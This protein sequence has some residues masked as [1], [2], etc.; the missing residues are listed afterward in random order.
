MIVSLVLDE[1]S[2]TGFVN[3][4][5]RMV[6][7]LSRARIACYLIG[8][9]NLFSPDNKDLPEHWQTVL[10]SLS[11]PTYTGG[12]SEPRLL[13]GCLP[14]S[15]SRFG[16]K[17]PL[18]C[19]RHREASQSFATAE[20]FP[21]PVCK[22]QCDERLQCGHICG[23]PCHFR[24]PK[25]HRG[26][27]KIVVD[28]PCLIHIGIPLH[29]DTVRT[30]FPRVSLDKALSLYQCEVQVDCLQPCGHK[31]ETSCA[32]QDAYYS[33]QKNWPKCPEIVTE[34]YILSCG[35]HLTQLPCNLYTNLL[36]GKRSEPTCKEA[37]TASLPCKHTI[38]IACSMK[39]QVESGTLEYVCRQKVKHTIAECGHSKEIQ[40]ERLTRGRPPTSSSSSSRR[41]F[42]RAQHDAE[43]ATK[44]Y[45]ESDEFLKTV[46][47]ER[48]YS[49]PSLGY[50]ICDS[51]VRFR[52]RCGHVKEM[53]CGIAIQTAIE[54]TGRCTELVSAY[55]S[56]CGHKVEVECGE[57]SEGGGGEYT[58]T[59]RAPVDNVGV[60]SAKPVSLSYL[61]FGLGSA[62]YNSSA[63]KTACN[64]KVS[65][66]YPCG[67][68]EQ[69]IPCSAA[70]KWALSGP[71][72][73][74]SAMKSFPHPL[75][76]HHVEAKCTVATVVEAW[77]PWGNIDI[78]SKAWDV[79]NEQ[80][81]L[82]GVCEKTPPPGAW[83][84]TENV[85]LLRGCGHEDAVPCKSA[86]RQLLAGKLTTCNKN[87]QVKLGCNHTRAVP[88]NRKEETLKEPCNTQVS[89][90]CFN[91]E[92]GCTGFT[93]GEC[94]KA[95]SG[96]AYYCD[97][98][99]DYTCNNGHSTALLCS[100]GVPDTCP[101]CLLRVAQDAADDAALE[102]ES[103]AEEVGRRLVAELR[104]EE[105]PLDF[106]L[107]KEGYEV[108]SWS[109]LLCEARKTILH[110]LAVTLREEADPWLR[111]SAPSQIL[112]P[113]MI[114]VPDPP[115]GAISRVNMSELRNQMVRQCVKNGVCGHGTY[116]QELSTEGLRHLVKASMEARKGNMKRK[117]KLPPSEM[118][119]PPELRIAVGIAI[120]TQPWTG[121]MPTSSTSKKKNKWREQKKKQGYDACFMKDGNICLFEVDNLVLLK[122]VSVQT[123]VIEAFLKSA[124]PAASSIP[125][126]RSCKGIQFSFPQG[127]RRREMIVENRE[128]VQ[129][130]VQEAVSAMGLIGVASPL[131]W[132]G[133]RIIFNTK[134]EDQEVE[135]E[136]QIEDGDIRKI[137][138]ELLEK[139]LFTRATKSSS[140]DPFRGINLAS[141]L[142]ERSHDALVCLALEYW[143][144]SYKDD[145]KK[146]LAKYMALGTEVSPLVFLAYGRIHSSPQALRAFYLLCPPSRRS[147]WMTGDEMTKCTV[148]EIE[149]SSSTNRGDGERN[150]HSKRRTIRDEWEELKK[151]KGYLCDA[152]DD[153]CQMIGLESVKREALDIVKTGM[154]LKSLGDNS[155]LRETMKSRRTL[156][157]LF[158]GNPGTG[159]SLVDAISVSVVSRIAL[160]HF[161]RH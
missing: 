19:P 61:F 37:V 158:L 68:S 25:D 122:D 48:K 147:F 28:R 30:A 12:D 71:E 42:F 17:L 111:K 22:E 53:K 36:S 87:S 6:V 149:Q 154:K 5:N 141:T 20:A 33:A 31:M 66:T 45:D 93:T 64:E 67:H 23:L 148:E 7:L 18:C 80:L 14:Y 140:G 157:Y 161:T 9:Q 84:C 15:G 153:L 47:E 58:P 160:T 130:V 52:F 115:P 38:K 121:N 128:V 103:K 144:L 95:N 127:G 26:P 13:R 133:Y 131:T 145:A 124:S 34:A 21:S 88:C 2:R 159:R 51:M 109:S 99:T 40:C 146:F 94:W 50:E 55:R 110:K 143:M 135:K 43:N 54:K 81:V 137:E 62:R 97:G 120:V 75:C 98:K 123:T 32:D 101:E 104:C 100:K 85:T 112:I 44:Y 91:K 96:E 114:V 108:P 117:N 150:A 116:V 139:M 73:N 113:T 4:K 24:T 125:I 69:S 63:K 142:A 136:G 132:D 29:C 8:Q 59:A 83:C 151:S 74:C 134:S 89:I 107:Q 82:K 60:D 106:L 156:N 78:P 3:L 90:S 152:M 76:G 105:K 77:R 126:E 129:E 1:N 11:D 39:E 16:R 138:E 27:C 56:Y 119:E 72:R 10:S 92:K 79:V 118:V 41:Y 65:F 86:F 35:H 102:A 155:E 57:L 70:S 46:F 49:P